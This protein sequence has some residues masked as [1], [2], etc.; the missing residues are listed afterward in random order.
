M[1]KTPITQLIINWF[2]F[3]G[4]K[5]LPW[6]KNQ[7]IYYIWISEIMLQQTQVNTVIPFYKKFITRFPSMKSLY[8]ASLDEILHYWSGLGYYTRAKNIYRTIQIIFKNKKGIFPENFFEIIQLPGIGK[9]TAG[10]ILSFSRNF[11]FSILD[12]NVKR[13]LVRYYYLINANSSKKF[14][15]I[16]WN[17]INIITPFHNTKQFNQSIMDIASLICTPKYPKCIICPLNL[18][19]LQ[20]KKNHQKDVYLLL[21]K[22]KKKNILKKYFCVILIFKNYIFLEKRNQTKIWNNLFCFPFFKKKTLVYNWIKS[23]NIKKKRS[24]KLNKIK[25]KYTNF[26]IEI[27]PFIIHMKSIFEPENNAI[28]F[29]CNSKQEIGLPQLV[30]KIIKKIRKINE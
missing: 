12:S 7:N 22:K 1:I 6:K 13:I 24:E 21:K 30:L 14:E 2:H 27:F 8:Q 11:S 18:Y 25:Y 5:Y 10:A 3:Y 19:C 28:W 16:L 26:N 20:Y 4:R 29:N 15:T 9:T 23:K 17:I